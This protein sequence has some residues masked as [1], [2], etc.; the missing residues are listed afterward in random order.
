[1][2]GNLN[3][4][5]SNF[6]WMAHAA[7]IYRCYMLRWEE[8]FSTSIITVNYRDIVRDPESISRKIAKF[9]DLDWQ[10]SMMEP[11][12]N[13]AMVRTASIVEVRQKVHTNSIGSWKN[14]AIPLRPFTENLIR[15]CGQK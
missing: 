9:C 8:L 4:Y 5:T 12:R 7:K 2:T 10:A 11:E 13:K 15:G 6:A 1:M 14:H 3:T